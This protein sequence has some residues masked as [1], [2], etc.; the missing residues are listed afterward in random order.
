[1]TKLALAITAT[2]LCLAAAANAQQAPRGGLRQLCAAD[3]QK[4]C[5]GMAP[6]EQH[7]CLMQ[8]MS[9]VSQACGTA[10]A[11][12]RSAM[13]AFA[14]ACRADI[15]QYCGT[16]APGPQRHQCVTANQAQFSQT[17]QSAIAAQ[18]GGAAPAH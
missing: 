8:N 11:N 15:Q 12:V 4:F 16:Q 7:K 3:A 17:C 1:M 6:A 2:M 9:N 5:A 18:R 13:K 14:Q 10:L